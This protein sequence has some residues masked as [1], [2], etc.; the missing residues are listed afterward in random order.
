LSL[1]LCSLF[2]F[3][4][5]LPL[6]EEILEFVVQ[7]LD[8]LVGQHK[9]FPVDEALDS[10]ELVHHYEVRVGVPEVNCIHVRAE[11]LGVQ[12]IV[13]ALLQLQILNATTYLE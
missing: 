1:L 8:L 3:L 12:L 7:V 2:S 6:V 9:C 5:L 4:E 10:V 13:T 11:E